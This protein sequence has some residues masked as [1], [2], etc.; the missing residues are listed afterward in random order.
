MADD[1][2]CPLCGRPIPEG[3][4]SSRHHL[5]PKLRGGARLGTV[6]LH[7]IRHSAI[8]ARYSETEIARR[9]TDIEALKSDPGMQDFIEWVSTKP[10][11]FHARTFRK[12]GRG[13]R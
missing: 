1:P 2:I 11:A 7:R 6:L 4:K 8:H 13:R 3:A 12:L 5:T 10:P 9:F